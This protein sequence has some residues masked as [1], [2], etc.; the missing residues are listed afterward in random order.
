MKNKG[1]SYTIHLS[2]RI[3]FAFLIFIATAFE[4]KVQGCL[5]AK[6]HLILELKIYPTWF[7]GNRKWVYPIGFFLQIDIEE[8]FYHDDGNRHTISTGGIRLGDIRLSANYWLVDPLK[9]TKGNVALGL[10]IKF[11]TGNEKLQ[12]SYYLQNGTELSDLDLAL[13]PGDGGWGIMLEAYWIQNI[14][15]ILSI[16]ASGYY[17][18]N[19]RNMNESVQPYFRPP[20][21]K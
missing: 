7:T 17:L 14:Y 13:H 8:S 16:Y 20:P 4:L 1:K 11:P 15:K 12:D 9:N 18:F 19:P 10:G 21:S 3:F 2:I 6:L 5:P